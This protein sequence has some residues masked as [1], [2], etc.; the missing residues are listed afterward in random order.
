MKK[1]LFIHVYSSDAGVSPRIGVGVG[2]G[3]GVDFGVSW[4]REEEEKR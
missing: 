4:E 3:V 1:I 2:A